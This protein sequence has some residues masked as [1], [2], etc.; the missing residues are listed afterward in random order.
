MRAGIYIGYVGH[1][2]LGDEAIWEVCRRRFPGIRWQPWGQL[3]YTVSLGQFAQ[4]SHRDFGYML[5]SLGEELLHQPRLRRMTHQ[6]I[7]RLAAR[8]G[9]EA[10]LLGGGTLING[11]DVY[12]EQ[13]RL[14]LERTGTTP[15]V[16][17]TGVYSPEFGSSQPGWKD[18]R[19]EWAEILNALPVIG[20]RGPQSKALLEDAGARNVVI[21]GDPAVAFHT[22]H[23]LNRPASDKLRRIGIN[24]GSITGGMWGNPAV[25]DEALIESARQ[26]S[27]SGVAVDL[28]A[29]CPEDLRACERVARVAGLPQSA[30]L[31]LL[32]TSRDFFVQAGNW[33]LVIALKL[34][35]AVL[36]AAA[37]VPMLVLEY[38][39]K[40]LDFASSIGWQQ[41][42]LRTDAVSSQR[43]L[44][45]VWDMSSA[46]PSIV[47]RLCE[48]VC[49]LASQFDSY[50]R[51]IEPLLAGSTLLKVGRPAGHT[52]TEHTR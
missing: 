13:Y 46:L 20:V 17:G 1:R 50:C 41:F 11:G 21:G 49:G 29:V 48:N 27:N 15:P 38:R 22:S 8:L 33:D 3:N 23:G 19:K 32:A 12:L 52:V 5:R 44:T 40:C 4:R 16:F 25:L 42:V 35:A 36:A 18:R 6:A 14:V 24:C 47:R 28:F 2:N 26:L 31:P 30:V 34:H 51:A 45:A 7:H 9:G 10:A 37:S 43:I 39:P